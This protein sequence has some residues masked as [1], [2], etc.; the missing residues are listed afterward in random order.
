MGGLLTNC[1]LS[2]VAMLTVGSRHLLQDLLGDTLLPHICQEACALA[3]G[4][5]SR[6]LKEPTFL[7]NHFLV[8]GLA[9]LSPA[10]CPP[11]P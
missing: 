4:A 7:Q 3:P 8:F 9:V 2:G 6:G 11:E 5:L 10:L 1:L